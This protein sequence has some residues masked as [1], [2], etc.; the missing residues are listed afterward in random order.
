MHSC[1]Y[2]VFEF[3]AFSTSRRPQEID[4]WKRS[5][6]SAYLSRSC[7][8]L[9]RKEQDP[10]RPCCFRYLV[11]HL[12]ACCE[13]SRTD[14]QSFIDSYVVNATLL[15]PNHAALVIYDHAS[16]AILGFAKIVFHASDVSR[17]VPKITTLGGRMM[18]LARTQ[19]LHLGKF[20]NPIGF[21]QH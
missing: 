13:I 4:S 11:A 20:L 7:A 5:L 1:H 6:V 12:H 17:S 18:Y 2:L 14:L 9:A 19:L 15:V 10:K 3:P 21:S 16:S 8:I